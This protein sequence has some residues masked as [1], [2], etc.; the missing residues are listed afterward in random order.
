MRNESEVCICCPI[1]SLVS[2]YEPDWHCSCRAGRVETKSESSNSGGE[3]EMTVIINSGSPGL[4]VSIA[5]VREI[6][7][8]KVPQMSAEWMIV[9]RLFWTLKDQESERD[10]NVIKNHS[11]IAMRIQKQAL[12][13][14]NKESEKFKV[15]DSFPSKKETVSAS[16]DG[17]FQ[18]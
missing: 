11:K 9:S 14:T 1:T 12:R 3:I 13:F 7:Q 10:P 5:I 8:T 17:S 4:K 16:T 2:L 18:N 6:Q 15:M